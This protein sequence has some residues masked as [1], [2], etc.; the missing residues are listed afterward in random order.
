M[1]SLYPDEIKLLGDGRH[2]CPKCGGGTN[3]EASLVVRTLPGGEVSWRC[4]RS[5]CGYG[6]GPRAA[7]GVRP[8]K[9]PRYFTRPIVPLIEHYVSILKQRFDLAPDAIDGYSIEDDRFV[10][11]VFGPVGYNKRGVIAYSMSGATPKSLT[12]NEKPAE[13]FIH[14]TGPGLVKH[15]VIVEDWFS[16]E[17]VAS[18]G[19]AQAV[20]LQGTH[21]DQAMVTEIATVATALRAPVWLAL[22]RDAYAKTVGYI[23]KYREQFP[24]GMYAWLLDQDLKYETRDRI[25]RGLDGAVNFTREASH[26]SD[27]QG[28]QSL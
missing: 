10:L 8:L 21:L 22:D 24:L 17:K 23:A 26:R 18:T 27:A 15:I 12:Y 19:E 5:S 3:K 14:W 28:S 11:P 16:A 6:G 2:I 9:D 20:A 13:P 7:P 1:K 4:F 25:K